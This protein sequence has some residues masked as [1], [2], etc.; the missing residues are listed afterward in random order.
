MRNTIIFLIVFA[1]LGLAV[2][3]L[4]YIPVV[5]FI[6]MFIG[7]PFWFGALLHLGLLA[8]LVLA[9]F[10]WLPRLLMIIPLAVWLAGGATWFLASRAVEA[11]SQALKTQITLAQV[12]REILIRDD[13]QLATELVGAYQL[14]A[15]YSDLRR[16]VLARAPD[17][18]PTTK[19]DPNRILWLPPKLR[20]RG[21]CV[22]SQRAEPPAG[23][24]EIARIKDQERTTDSGGERA[25]M[26]VTAFEGGQPK[27]WTIT[28]GTESVPMPLIYPII[29][30]FYGSQ[31][32]E[33]GTI[34][35]MWHYD[36]ALVPGAAE[37][38]PNEAKA[39]L[40]GQ[41]LGLKRR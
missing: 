1:V 33:R 4:Q 12:P 37:D 34:L 36:V 7:M 27:S 20:A 29:G 24:I 26:K 9:A 40:I 30:F 2:I 13:D 25:P 3:G 5:G 18:T 32:G 17:C 15:V 6:G 8:M 14:D 19:V 31:A 41:S 10:G 22:I 38:E 23:L 16:H 11:E 39:R 21:E 28:Y 35:D